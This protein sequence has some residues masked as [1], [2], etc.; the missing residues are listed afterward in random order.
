MSQY[1]T[2]T[3]IPLFEN[4]CRRTQVDGKKINIE[5]GGNPIEVDVASTHKSQAKGYMGATLCPKDG[6]GKLFVY[7]ADLPLSFW[8][9]DVPFDLDVI[10]FDSGLNYIG[11]ETMKKYKGQ[12]DHELPRYSSKKPARFAVETRPG[13]CKEKGIDHNCKLKI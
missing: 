1:T 10:F 11:H 6:E 3:V 7:D 13:W 5:I 4:F 8:M 12:A 2:K 9:K